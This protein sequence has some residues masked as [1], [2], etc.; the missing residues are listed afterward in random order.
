MINWRTEEIKRIDSKTMKM[1]TVY[2]VQ[3]P[4]A[5][6]DRLYVQRKEEGRGLVQI[7]ATYK[8]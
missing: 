6:T 1:L 7:E 5:D 3:H 8:A 4:T 2:K